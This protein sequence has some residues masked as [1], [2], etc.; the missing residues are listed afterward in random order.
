MH[1]YVRWIITLYYVEYLFNWT[2][3]IMWA[4]KNVEN[5]PLFNYLYTDSIYLPNKFHFYLRLYCNRSH[6]QMTYHDVRRRKKSTARDVW[7]VWHE[8]YL[9]VYIYSSYAI[10]SSSVIY[11]STEAQKLNLFV[12]YN[13]KCLNK[14]GENPWKDFAEVYH[15]IGWRHPLVYTI[16]M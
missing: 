14:R 5:W 13:K 15:A 11:C 12:L 4:S 3:L 6:S 10:L 9:F 2:C 7:D 16:I 1:K 8:T